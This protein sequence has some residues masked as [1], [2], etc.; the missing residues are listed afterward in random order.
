MLPDATLRGDY[1]EPRI[2]GIHGL[3]KN[4][5]GVWNPDFVHAPVAAVVDLE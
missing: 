3:I 2:V 5:M 4:P 1:P